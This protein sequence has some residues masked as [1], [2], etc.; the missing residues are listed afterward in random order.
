MAT[1]FYLNKGSIYAL[2][3]KQK[4]GKRLRLEY[5]PGI[6]IKD[7][8]ND[9]NSEKQRP[10]DEKLKQEI[11]NIQKQINDVVNA[12]DPFTLNND[13]FANLLNEKLTGNGNNTTPFFYAFDIVYEKTKKKFGERRAQTIKNTTNKLREFN[14]DIT[15]DE[16]DEQFY[17]E[18]IE[19]C[20]GQNMMA[21]YIGSIIRDIKKVMDYATTNK[22][23]TNRAYQDFKKPRERVYNIYLNE[24]EI[25]RIYDL[26]I[27][28]ESI[29]KLWAR[30]DKKAKESGGK[31]DS[32][33]NSNVAKQIQSLNHVRKLFVVGCWT[34]L[35]CENYLSI[36]PEIQVDLKN[37]VLHAIANKNGPKLEIP[38]HWIAKEIFESGGFPKPISSQKLN[39]HAK[40][41]GFLAGITEPIMYTR[42][43]GGIRKTFVKEKCDMITSHTARRSLASNLVLRGAPYQYVMA[44]TG[45][46]TESSFRLYIGAVEKDILT[47]K[48]KDLPV[49]K[50]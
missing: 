3:T 4:N 14:P 18:F 50:K 40:E 10:K 8:Q 38:L 6:V 5:Y 16:I 32:H 30:A 1:G 35:R 7:P 26:K 37:E 45:H 11:D 48:L 36:D 19:Y 12:I 25:Q 27:N 39:E 13:K 22:I 34:G 46:E 43:V 15:F 23:N 9:W 41:L 28:E 49:W 24:D 21:N 29:S 44:I 20:E 2:Y 42:T 17:S 47:A 33:K 31:P